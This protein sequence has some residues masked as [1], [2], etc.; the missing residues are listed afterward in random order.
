MTFEELQ[1][2]KT[3]YEAA[4][5]VHGKA[6]F[7]AEL[8]ALFAKHEDVRAVQWVQYTPYFNDGDPCVFR[9]YTRGVMLTTDEGEVDDFDFDEHY[10]HKFA[11][12][13][14]KM[15]DTAEDVLEVAFGES[16]KVTCH[17]DGKIAVDE[18]DHD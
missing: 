9:A 2:K 1:Q 17:R 11:K 12:A 7:A 6:A 10:G 14:E 3:E 15:L 4:M 5:K 18:Y 16:S 8:K 13:V